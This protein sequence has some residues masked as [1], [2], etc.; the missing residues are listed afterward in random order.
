MSTRHQIRTSTYDELIARNINKPENII[1]IKCNILEILAILCHGFGITQIT[2]YCR[3]SKKKTVS[4]D[5][6][7][8]YL[9]FIEPKLRKLA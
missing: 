3:F 4:N 5:V 2:N 9:H 8:D 6:Y 7:Y 1:R